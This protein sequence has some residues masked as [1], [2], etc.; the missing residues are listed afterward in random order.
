MSTSSA[1]NDRRSNKK[2]VREKEQ[3]QK[4][5][6]I[7]DAPTVR[8][9]EK[10]ESLKF[11]MRAFEKHVKG[12]R[13]DFSAM[14]RFN[15]Y[16]KMKAFKE[17]Q[18]DGRNRYKDVGCLDNNRVKLGAPWPHQYVHANYVAVPNNPKRFICT[19]A[20]LEKTCA[21]FWW[22]CLQ[23]RVETIFMLCNYMEKGAKKCHEYLPTEEKPDTLTFKEKSQKVTVKFESAAEFKFSEETKAKV[24]K[25]I[26]TVEGPGG[27][28]GKVSHYHWI[29]WPDRGV[30]EADAAILEL[31]EE[32]RA[33]KGPIVVHCSAGIGRTGS[34]VMLEYMMDQLLNNQAIEESTKI[35]QKIRDQR[36][37]SI[38]TDHQYLFVHQVLLNQIRAKGFFNSDAKKSHND[39]TTDYKKV[40]QV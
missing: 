37:N 3:S 11:A 12:L 18:E 26:L 31:L 2:T 15:D 36:N 24:T 21:D 33:T 23:D 30:P 35:L 6:A 10:K 14:R 4:T 22:M 9:K 20:P 34:V 8:K 1:K 39:F 17:A 27:A 19:Q 16:T 13:A 7:E 28:T 38:Q 29:D 40:T 5:A 25:T 32:A